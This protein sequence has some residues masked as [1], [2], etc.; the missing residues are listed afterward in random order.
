LILRSA[1]KTGSGAESAA[2]CREQADHVA[3]VAGGR[4]APIEA[5]SERVA[6]DVVLHRDENVVAETAD[7]VH[8]GHARVLEA[9]HRLRFAQERSTRWGVPR[10]A[11]A[12]A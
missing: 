4:A 7:V 6:Y 1:T 12:R 11:R 10:V 8:R 2:G 9:R 5:L 3:P